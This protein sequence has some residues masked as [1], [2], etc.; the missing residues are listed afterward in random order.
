MHNRSPG[1]PRT[2]HPVLFGIVKENYLKWMRTR[3]KERCKESSVRAA[4]K[5]LRNFMAYLQHEEFDLQNLTDEHIIE[6]IAKREAK[7][8]CANTINHELTALGAMLNYV[9][10]IMK[11]W[12]VPPVNIATH[13]FA[14]KH[15]YKPKITVL[16]PDEFRH[17]LRV[18]GEEPSSM[19]APPDRTV[20]V[21]AIAYHTGL[22]HQ[23]IAHL[24]RRDVDFARG[25]LC[26]T[27]KPAWVPK[28]HEEREIPLGL[29]LAELFKIYMKDNVGAAPESWVFEGY[30]GSLYSFALE[31]REAFIR[32]GLGDEK[33]RPGLHMLRRTWASNLLG[34]KRSLVEVM[35]LGGWSTIASVQRYLASTTDQHRE[36]I[37]SL[38]SLY[39]SPAQELKPTSAPAEAVEAALVLIGE[40]MEEDELTYKQAVAAMKRMQ[41]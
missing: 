23:E 2:K 26:V 10:I 39:G 33:R 6:Y 20:L 1:R 32:A 40:L 18:A 34:N 3:S 7:G 37:A 35:H 4:C 5:R 12:S 31:V 25:M 41:K 13:R 29:E 36:A 22:R 27:R 16:T 17:L 19:G 30:A 8:I 38:P 9:T 11:A 24:W 14:E 28:D 21:L 15:I